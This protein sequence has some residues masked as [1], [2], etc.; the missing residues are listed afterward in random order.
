MVWGL[1]CI[2]GLH[3]LVYQIYIPVARYAYPVI[4]PTLLVLVIGWWSL[5]RA[6]IGTVRL[7]A[8]MAGA[9]VVGSMLLFDVYSLISLVTFYAGR[10]G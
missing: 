6:V 2:R 8:W 3:S 4:V 5:A 7:P 10:T 9:S 1:A